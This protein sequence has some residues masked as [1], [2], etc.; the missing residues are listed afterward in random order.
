PRRPRAACLVVRPASAHRLSGQP[1]RN[2]KGNRMSTTSPPSAIDPQTNAN[3]EQ[4]VADVDRGGRN[5][6]GITGAVLFC[7]AVFWSLFQLWYASP[8][9]FALNLGI[10]NDTEARALHLGI[11]MFLGYLAYPARKSSPRDKMPLIDWVLAFIAGF[12]GAYLFL[13]YK[14]LATR[15][16]IPTLMDITV[17]SIGLLLLLEVTRRALGA[18]MAILGAV[19]VSYVFL[20]PWLPDA[21]AHRGASIERLV[22]HMWLTT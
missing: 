17:A 22:S 10:F 7:G 13:F 3:L 16:G 6:G 18:P 2:T 12:C 5:V 1:D 11:A 14:E 8:L 21:L 4:L 20:G 19:F 15:P 9:P